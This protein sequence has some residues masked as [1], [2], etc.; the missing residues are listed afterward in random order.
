MKKALLYAIA[1]ALAALTSPLMDSAF[2][3]PLLSVW[4]L[5]ETKKPRFQPEFQV[6]LQPALRFKLPGEATDIHD[7]NSP[8]HWDNGDLHIFTSHWNPIGHTYHAVARSL[9]ES[10]NK[11]YQRVEY[12]S[13]Q[14]PGVGKWIESTHRMADG[15]LYGWYHTEI[16]AGCPNPK[17]V[18]PSIGA[19]RSTDNGA[20]WDDF[21]V[22]M[23][24][25]DSWTD[26]NYRN[27]FF[28]GGH[29]D[30]SVIPDRE[31]KY[32]YFFFTNY[33]TEDDQQGIAMARMSHKYLTNPVG[34][35]YKW[36]DGKFQEP[37]ISGSATPV[38]GVS[39]SWAEPDPQAYWGPAI[40]YNSYLKAYVVL[41][42][43]TSGGE[44]D[45]RQDGIYIS[46][47][48]D[49]TDPLHWSEP[50]R[51]YDQGRW[52]PQVIGTN[53]NETDKLAGQK[54]RFFMGGISHYTLEFSKRP[55]KPAP[56]IV[57]QLLEK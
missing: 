30:F 6:S 51:I 31:G 46:Y 26:C 24:G 13:E 17:I 14:H 35:V 4:Q 47:N 38:F 33:V 1:I 25:N 7:C 48:D 18:I 52:Y 15:T 40:H 32:F 21:G 11:P 56:I 16:P 39:K 55:R 5:A 53:K 36:Y 23:S 49:I 43:F 34:H 9:S 45:F 44:S 37:G 10:E 27:G 29:G 41:L 3:D 19:A 28:S 20:T 54:P 42:N 50:I 57:S 2:S 12:R 22:I 8:L